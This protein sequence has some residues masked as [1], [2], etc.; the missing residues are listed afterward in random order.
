M[1]HWA[2]WEMEFPYPTKISKEMKD[3]VATRMEKKSKAVWFGKYVD[4]SDC[5]KLV[6]DKKEPLHIFRTFYDDELQME[7]V[8]HVD[9]FDIPRQN[10]LL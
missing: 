6:N 4:E 7:C 9:T 2:S 8:E 10:G 3:F 1:Y 5:M